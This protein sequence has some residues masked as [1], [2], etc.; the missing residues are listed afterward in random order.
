MKVT[1]L[2]GHRVWAAT[3]DSTP[4]PL[5]A[6]ERRLLPKLLGEAAGLRALDLACGTGHWAAYL[7]SCGAQAWGVDFC[8]EMLAC[9]HL[10]L[11]GRLVAG[12]AGRLPFS[13][14]CFDLVVCSF[15]L[16]Y[17]QDL[18]AALREAARMAVR[19]ARVLL[20]DVHPEAI[21][22]GWS[23]SF[24]SGTVR[25]EIENTPHSFDTIRRCAEAAGLALEAEE[26]A[27]F[28]APELPIFAQ[29]GKADAFAASAGIPAVWIS[30]WS[31]R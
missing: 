16:G 12:A 28:G 5:L 11:R 1:A 24:R 15:A 21:A 13:A 10:S 7:A 18:D 9:A 31:K 17:L 4:N 25:Y 8:G 2:E 20:S 19:G 14:A 29:A 22:H 6:L 30:R 27:G 23:R 3:Y 26:H